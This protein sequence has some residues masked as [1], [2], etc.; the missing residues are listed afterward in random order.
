MLVQ[1]SSHR[2]T[3]S[4]EVTFRPPSGAESRH[5]IK[6]GV[7]LWIGSDQR[8]DCA[9]LSPDDEG[10]DTVGTKLLGKHFDQVIQQV[11]AN[12]IEAEETYFDIEIDN[13]LLDDHLALTNTSGN[14]EPVGS[15]A[16]AVSSF[17]IEFSLRAG[18]GVPM[19]VVIDGT[20]E[21]LRTAVVHLPESNISSRISDSSQVRVVWNPTTSELKVRLAG[22]VPGD[23]RIWVRVA[24]GESGDLLAVDRA[25]VQPDGSAVSSSI[26]P[27]HGEL[28]ELY[29]DVTESPTDIIGSSRYRVRRRAARLEA[30]AADLQRVGKEAESAAVREK[31]NSL[32][33]SLGEESGNMALIAPTKSDSKWWIVAILAVLVG[34]LI[35]WFM[36]GDGSDS[37]TSSINPT[38]TLV[39]ESSTSMAA[40]QPSDQSLI[41]YRPGATRFSGEGNVN[42]AAEVEDVGEDSATVRIQIYDQYERS[43][44]QSTPS[45]QESL[46]Q[47]CEVSIGSDTGSGGGSYALQTHIAAFVAETSEE[48]KLLLTA[49]SLRNPVA[50]FVGSV[51]MTANI[52][53]S[54]EV[55][56]VIDQEAV[57]QIARS[58]FETFTLDIPLNE[59]ETYVVLRVINERGSSVSWTSTEVLKI[60]K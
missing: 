6:N 43:L 23:G 35:G 48:A 29:V 39:Q 42:L 24:L 34:S 31:A 56:R 17:E 45:T 33:R 1:I 9:L 20:P 27:H 60:E 18:D 49:T 13:S 22:V 4:I 30:Y 11:R 37:A 57:I 40:V 15:N 51:S 38:S 10:F 41:A 19:E 47:T 36:R 26:V 16:P 7:H 21:G 50:E 44:G 14:L 12:L 54:C 32:R 25:R 46:M 2:V 5:V 8:I 58:A 28:G 53:E 55:R 59:G 52:V 3:G